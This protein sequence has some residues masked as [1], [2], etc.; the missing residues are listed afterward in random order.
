MKF[1]QSLILTLVACGTFQMSY[2]YATEINIIKID[3]DTVWN[4]TIDA[5]YK[6]GKVELT[7]NVDVPT[8]TYINIIKSGGSSYPVVLE[9]I[10]FTATTKDGNIIG[11]S[12]NASQIRSGTLRLLKSRGTTNYISIK[13]Y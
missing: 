13:N 11:K 4:V 9:E 5:T 8:K 7:T 2:G 1:L 12:I 10:S 3:N 6:Y